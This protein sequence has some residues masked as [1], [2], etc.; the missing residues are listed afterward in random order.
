MGVA[1][2]RHRGSSRSAL[3][4]GAAAAAAAAAALTWTASSAGQPDPTYGPAS[5]D[6]A[7]SDWSLPG[8]RFATLHKGGDSRSPVAATLFLRYDCSA[9]VLY[10]L[11]LAEP[12]VLLRTDDAGETYLRIDDASKAV[13][14][15]SGDDGT[16]PDFAWVGEEG[17]RA[18]G[19]EASARVPRGGHVLR[20]HAKMASED[21]D[22]YDALDVAGRT[23]P[24]ALACPAPGVAPPPATETAPTPGAPGGA[25][26]PEAAPTT[27][28]VDLEIAKVA[29]PARVRVGARSTF[30]VTVRN[31]GERHASAVVVEDDLPAGVALA[32]ASASQ[33]SCSGEGRVVCD[34]GGLAPGAVA[35]VAIVVV[36]AVPGEVTNVARTSAQ[37]P[38][39][40]PADNEARATLTIVSAAGQRLGCYWLTASRGTLSVDDRTVIRVTVRVRGKRVPRIRVLAAGAGYR[41]ARTTNA[42]GVATFAVTPRR[43]G[44]IRFAVARGRTCGPARRLGVA[45]RVHEQAL[46]G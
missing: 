20:V 28:P 27:V 21:A 13:H 2:R 30:A 29:D 46:T 40:N 17:F 6:G 31:K 39:A 42:R 24:L 44:V 45:G 10:A 4:L 11:V 43:A 36:G 15:K 18:R 41:A 16:P 19:F 23:V 38:D 25:P 9:G 12:G 7:T 14:G 35:T 22:G 3:G 8:D 34:L 5:V 33:G 32:S 26:A 37:Q 1:N